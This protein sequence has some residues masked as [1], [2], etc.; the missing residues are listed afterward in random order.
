MCLR[1]GPCVCV[2]ACGCGWVCMGRVYVVIWE[3]S[4]R[5]KPDSEGLKRDSEG[6]RK[7][8][9]ADYVQ[10]KKPKFLIFG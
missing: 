1:V 10:A 4:R 7:E 6:L 9:K 8:M 2:R 5:L 3:G